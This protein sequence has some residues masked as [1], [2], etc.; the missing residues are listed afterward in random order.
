MTRCIPMARLLALAGL[1]G[2][3]LAQTA[4]AEEPPEP[5][6][7]PAPAPA[8]PAP[9]APEQVL[10]WVAQ[11]GS[12]DFRARE[13]ASER[14]AGAGEA[15]REALESAVATSDSLEVRW[16]AQQLLLRL[17]G[18]H[19][20]RLGA[21]EPGRGGNGPP[22]PGP[23]LPGPGTPQELREM[24][25]RMLEGLGQGFG[26]GGGWPGI[27]VAPLEGMDLLGGTFRSGA[28]TLRQGWP[29]GRVRLEV[30]GS[31]AQGQ[32]Q[33]T[34]YDGASLEALLAAHPELAQHPDLPGLK[35]DMEERQRMRGLPPGTRMP[36]FSFRTSEGLEVMQDA[37]GA[38]VRVHER[39]Q[40]GSVVTKEYRGATLEDIRREHPEL[41]DRLGGLTLRVAPP[42][43][44]RGPREEPMPPLPPEEAP[45][46]GAAGAPEA[47][48]GVALEPVEGLLARHLK[49]EGRAALL[50][51]EV[52]PGSQAEA[53]GV[54]PLDIVL[55]I[56]G[57]DVAGMDDAV[58]RLRAAA[59]ASAALR[60]DLLRAGAPLTL[61]R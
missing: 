47:R 3:L 28:L 6:P 20:R 52:V 23:R 19:E 61:T 17:D 46:P 32:P 43:V 30:R 48:F 29:G 49:L 5:T 11:L 50:V 56:D 9:P 21:R 45:A 15:A 10:A 39:A 34:T 38:T 57:K 4:R 59:R 55:A 26:P 2:G 27:D 18:R 42:R 37:A 8:E 13:E 12:D 51:R 53:L 36:M 7:V 25:E 40:D 41:A 16:R 22:G 33:R 60:L 44:F 35:K 31:D 14:L 58:E 54:Q 1:C 24:V